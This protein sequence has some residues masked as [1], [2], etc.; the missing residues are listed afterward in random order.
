[1]LWTIVGIVLLIV[2]VPVAIQVL[3]QGLVAI[4]EFFFGDVEGLMI[5]ATLVGLALFFACR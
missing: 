4:G 3:G 1:M 5:L 2:F